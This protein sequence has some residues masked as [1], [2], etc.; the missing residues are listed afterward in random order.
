MLVLPLPAGG[1][2][3]HWTRNIIA[4]AEAMIQADL[5]AEAIAYVSKAVA[6]KPDETD[7]LFT[8]GS[9][10]ERAGNHDA[11]EKAF[12]RLLEKHPDH[13]ATLNYLGY[14]WAE[15]GRNLEKAH[16]ML[17]RAVTQEPKNG[18]YVDSLGWVYFRL[19][20][21]EL[22]EKYLTDATSLVP[23]D[24]PLVHPSVEP[25]R[26]AARAEGQ[27]VEIDPRAHWLPP[28]ATPDNSGPSGTGRAERPGSAVSLRPG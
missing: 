18:A 4:T 2:N 25:D 7:L 8:L 10:H 5:E 6:A 12:L 19:G 9:A 26:V 1:Y 20:N 27:P 3:N 11:A 21:L 28:L 14:M 23:R 22:A 17:V 24:D 16:E 13:A 15:S